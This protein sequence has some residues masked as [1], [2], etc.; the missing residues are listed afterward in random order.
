MLICLALTSE[1]YAHNVAAISQHTTA[2]HRY[3]GSNYERLSQYLQDYFRQSGARH[4]YQTPNFAF[5]QTIRK[6]GRS[7]PDRGVESAVDNVGK[8]SISTQLDKTAKLV[9]LRGQPSSEWLR[10]LGAVYH[11]DPEFYQRHLD[12]LSTAGRENHFVLPSLPSAS[13]SIVQLS[14]FTISKPSVLKDLLAHEAKST[15][16]QTIDELRRTSR[17]DM[18]S[19]LM[20]LTQHITLESSIGD[21]IVRDFHVF[22]SLHFAL[23]QRMTLTVT[24]SG[25]GENFT[26]NLII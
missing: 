20:N 10:N 3:P 25:D 22:D 16:P 15:G 26:G 19:H 23:E 12:F 5:V 9:F 4:R 11:I 21:S 13:D 17:Q 14:Y 6:V 18:D 24:T 8:P 2:R 7:I 1:Q